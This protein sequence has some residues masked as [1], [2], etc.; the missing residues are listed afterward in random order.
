MKVTQVCIGKFHHFHLARQLAECGELAAIFSGYPWFRLKAEGVPRE[1]VR[2]YPWIQTLYMAGLRYGLVSKSPAFQQAM[3]WR[4]HQSLDRY[5]ARHL[6][7]CDVVVGL[8][9]S[10]L[11]TGASAAA[12]REVRLRPGFFAHSVSESHLA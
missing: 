10:A 3:E 6:P 5:A 12:G 11:Q 8:S 4:S 9:G 7:P 1:L 2:S